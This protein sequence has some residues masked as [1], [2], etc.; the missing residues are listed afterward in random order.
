MK[1]MIFV[2]F[3]TLLLGGCAIH[4]HNDKALTGKGNEI[5]TPYGAVEGAEAN[6][7]SSLDI[8]IPYKFNETN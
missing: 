1:N 5:K 3:A 2:V 7:N 6:F 8:W 4:Y